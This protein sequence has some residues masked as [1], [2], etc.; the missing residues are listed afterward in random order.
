[1]IPQPSTKQKS[2]CKLTLAVISLTTIWLTILPMIA[3]Q[4][5]VAARIQRLEARGI[6]PTAIFYTEL[7]AMEAAEARVRRLRGTGDEDLLW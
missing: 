3:Q 6:D 7:D 1:M 4:P 2:W 5:T